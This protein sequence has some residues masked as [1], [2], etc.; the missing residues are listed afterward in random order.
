[1]HSS[2]SQLSAEQRGIQR[3]ASPPLTPPLIRSA[4]HC[5]MYPQYTLTRDWIAVLD[6]GGRN[7]GLAK[8][9]YFWSATR[10]RLDCLIHFSSVFSGSSFAYTQ[11]NILVDFGDIP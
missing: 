8:D 1:M 6:I 10:Y 3:E 11:E 5:A 7:D 9:N 2:T 4:T